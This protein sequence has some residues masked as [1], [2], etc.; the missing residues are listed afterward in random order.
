ML[1]SIVAMMCCYF[2]TQS[3]SLYQ[4]TAVH[5]NSENT[6]SFLPFTRH[7]SAVAHNTCV[8][9]SCYVTVHVS[10]CYHLCAGSPSYQPTSAVLSCANVSQDV[11]LDC[12][13]SCSPCCQGEQ[14]LLDSSVTDV[15]LQH[16]DG[17]RGSSLRTEVIKL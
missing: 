4:P 5:Q 17:G 8:H 12:G 7:L 6:V 1:I 10:S 3:R 13:G 2:L 15:L 11:G 9:W 14:Q 16:Q